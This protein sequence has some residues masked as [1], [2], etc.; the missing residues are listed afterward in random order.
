MNRILQYINETELK[1]RPQ[2]TQASATA[3]ATPPA[4]DVELLDAYSRA[5]TD[6][7]K[8]VGPSVVNIEVFGVDPRDPQQRVRRSGAGSGFVFTPDGFLLTN[9]HVVHG[10]TKIEITL[11]NGD[12]YDA[13][14]IGD[15]PDTDLA[16]LR[17]DAPGLVPAAF[18]DSG[19]LQVGQVAIAIGNPLGFQ[20]T[21]T[22]GVVSATGR[23]FRSSTGRLIDNLIQ[24]DAALNPGNSGGPLVDSRGRVIGVNTA[25]IMG[26]QGL[27][28]AIPANTAKYV[29]ARLIKDGKIVRSYIGVAGQN[30]PLHRK[31]VRHYDLVQQ[32]GVLVAG[33]EPASPASRAGLEE[34]DVIIRFDDKP[35]ETIDDLH[36]L[37]AGETIGQD[38]KLTV[39]RRTERLELT[40]RPEESRAKNNG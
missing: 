18:G 28:F 39:F 12:R 6:V 40:V 25:V 7:V 1:D 3:V 33:V 9:S 14:V 19:A 20:A 36:R 13:R 38:Q 21:V 26:T 15:D 32:T 24:T 5:V 37:L 4:E 31:L 16:V 27:C 8:L 17:T 2:A 35:V 22:A 10:A 23:S 29:A 11:N 34:G 30:V